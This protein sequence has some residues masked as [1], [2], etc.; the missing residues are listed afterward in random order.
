MCA[1]LGEA[2]LNVLIAT[3]YLSDVVD[4]AGALGTKCSDEQGNTGADIWAGHA[5]GTQLYFVVV[6]DDYST[7]WIAKD[8]LSSHIDEFINEEQTALKHF[9]MEQH[10]TP[11]LCGYNQ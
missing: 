7:V 8:N 11:G 6:A 5:P 4:A 1:N 2:I 9:L 3:V 10:A